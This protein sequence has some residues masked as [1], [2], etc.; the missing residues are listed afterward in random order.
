MESGCDC[1]FCQS[2]VTAEPE[3]GLPT[4]QGI[5]AAVQELMEDTGRD[6]IVVYYFSGH[7]SELYGR[8]LYAGQRFQTIVT[9][10]SGRAGAENRDIADR[11]IE[12]WIRDFSRRTPYLTMIFDCCHSGGVTDLRS[13]APVGRLVKA[14]ERTEAAAYASQLRTIVQE[15][16]AGDSRTSGTGEE[17][18][19]GQTGWLRGAGRSAIVLTASAAKEYSSETKVEGR[20]QGLFTC[21]LTRALAEQDTAGSTWAD[22]FPGIAEAVTAENLSQHPRREGSSLI[23]A[24][25]PIDL[26]DVYP[27]DVVELKKLAIVIG[28]DYKRSQEEA[29]KEDE[30]RHGFPPLQAPKRD[31]EEVARVLEELQGYEIVGISSSR[32]GP[33]LNQQATRRGIHQVINRLVRVKARTHRES[34]VLIY[35]AGHGVVRTEENGEHVGYLVPWDA[36]RDDPTTWLPMKDLRDHLVDGIWDKERLGNLGR[37]QPLR[38]LTSRHLLLVLDCCFGGALSFDFFRGGDSPDR[39][40]YYSEYKRFV[41]GSA[42]QLLTSASYN[43]QAMDRDPKGSGQR[44]SPFA[45][46]LIEGLTTDSAD[47]FRLGSRSDQII[48]ATE[49]HQHVDS[50]LKQ[51]GVDIQTPGL[52]AL[53]PMRG[54]YIFH[55]PG[56][57]PTPL[58][59]PPLTPGANP[60]RGELAYGDA[61]EDVEQADELFYGRERALLELLDCFLAPRLPADEQTSE[62]R[63]RPALAIAGANGSGKTSLVRAGLLPLLADPVRARRRIRSWLHRQQEQHLLVSAE[64]LAKVREWARSRSLYHLLDSPQ[65]LANTVTQWADETGL[66]DATE[67]RTSQ[68]Q[69]LAQME[70]LGVPT[71]EEGSGRVEERGWLS[72]LGLLR[73]LDW[74]DRLAERLR[75]WLAEGGLADFLSKPDKEIANIVGRWQ[76]VDSYEDLSLPAGA[77]D[78]ELLLVLDRLET[79]ATK[80]Q[81]ESWRSFAASPRTRTVATVSSGAL[82]LEP[83][84]RQL[85]EAADDSG[86]PLWQLYQVPAP[87]RSELRE[88]VTG[89]AAARALELEP[90]ELADSLVEEVVSTPAPLALLSL[91]L[92]AMYERAW[93]RSRGA[94]RQ[95]CAADQEPLGV[96]TLLGRLAESI[97]LGEKVRRTRRRLLCLLMRCVSFDGN[98]PGRRQVGWHEL[99]GLLDPAMQSLLQKMMDKRLLIAGKTHIELVSDDLIVV[100]K[101]LR[102]AAR[103]VDRSPGGLHALWQRALEWQKSGCDRSKLRPQDPALPKLFWSQTL[104]QLERAFVIACSMERRSLAATALATTSR[105][106]AGIGNEWQRRAMLAVAATEVAFNTQDVVKRLLE[107]AL[108]SSEELSEA[109]ELARKARSCSWYE[110]EQ[111]MHDA[112]AATPL[113]V[114]LSLPGESTACSI[115]GLRFDSD[116]Q[117]LVR[118]SDGN[119]ADTQTEPDAADKVYAWSLHNLS[120]PASLLTGTEPELPDVGQGEVRPKRAPIGNEIELPA[121]TTGFGPAPPGVNPKAQTGHDGVVR[122]FASKESLYEQIH[123]SMV[124]APLLGHQGIPTFLTFSRSGRWLVSAANLAGKGFELRLWPIH[125]GCQLPSHPQS[126]LGKTLAEVLRRQQQA[127][128]DYRLGGSQLDSLPLTV[129]VAGSTW[130]IKDFAENGCSFEICNLDTQQTRTVELPLSEAPSDSADLSDLRP[131]LG[132]PELPDRLRSLLPP[133]LL[134]SLPTARRRQVRELVFSSDGCW[135]AAMTIDGTACLWSLPDLTLTWSVGGGGIPISGEESKS[136]WP[137][138]ITCL[139]FC[140]VVDTGVLLAVGTDTGQPLFVDRSGSTTGK[141]VLQ[142]LTGRISTM[143]FSPCGQRLAIGYLDGTVQLWPTQ[144]GDTT[145][146]VVLRGRRHQGFAVRDLAFDDQ[147]TRLVVERAAV[148]EP[149]QHRVD[150]YQ[151]DL[152]ELVMLACGHAGRGPKPEDLPPELQPFLH[153]SELKAMEER[154]EE[155]RAEK[156]E[157]ERYLTALGLRDC[158]VQSLDQSGDSVATYEQ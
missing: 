31:A 30:S 78:P 37:K 18:R 61:T 137:L 158:T 120:Q 139:A 71:F 55:V 34:A 156:T 133:G 64:D 144:A 140:P 151:L 106:L 93:H 28:I 75:L 43:Q 27:P 115:T 110:A 22:I 130:Q 136:G 154:K 90:P 41:E 97:Y 12:G 117:L 103:A 32:P 114:P 2:A 99:E 112:L 108:P 128:Q 89:P 62:T 126:H 96:A 20:K 23:F 38:R 73:L 116:D 85:L 60:W 6:D 29:G 5:I 157:M 91:N 119:C 79:C 83:S 77:G 46:A 24:P 142:D 86:R 17:T 51:M 15:Q 92:S 44:H 33:L 58:P 147:G 49:L 50:R 153:G 68:M 124:P 65:E 118:I 127:I 141:P 87:T 104:N 94:D 52:T 88:I 7:G 63:I 57:R 9:H 80:I 35:F 54:Q 143:V 66:L 109:I 122:F 40:I 84:L 135:L 42:W 105:A 11:E 70:S 48:T 26:D 25:G 3:P 121:V 74:P 53:R 100:W 149:H 82:G 13:S 152:G 47:T 8:G 19:K 21:Q 134:K 76:V 125:E 72:R 1:P 39:P 113:S 145:G 155:R 16:Q 59:D 4:R 131:P 81:G 138:R 56:F 45:E 98:R 101:R 67:S 36:D 69:N 129:N 123:L 132:L 146:P 150:V 107:Q 95:L 10:D 102:R 14:D 111:A 148:Y